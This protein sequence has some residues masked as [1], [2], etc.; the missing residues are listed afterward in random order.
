MLDLVLAVIDSGYEEFKDL[1]GE[2]WRQEDLIPTFSLRYYEMKAKLVFV[3]RARKLSFKVD[4]EQIRV[5]YIE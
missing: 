5:N 3:M 4:P 1:S 2:A